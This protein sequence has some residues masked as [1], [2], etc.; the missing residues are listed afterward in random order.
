[1]CPMSY[2]AWAKLKTQKA[3]QMHF[4][5]TWFSVRFGYNWLY[6]A[7][8]VRW[9]N[10][11]DS[12]VLLDTEH[13]QEFNT[14]ALQVSEIGKEQQL[15]FMPVSFGVDRQI[16]VLSWIIIHRTYFSLLLYCQVFF[17]LPVVNKNKLSKTVNT[18]NQ[19][20]CQQQHK[21]VTALWDPSGRK[22]TGNP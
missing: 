9:G 2:G 12:L 5:H 21:Y 18:S 8:K 11:I 14:A 22:R 3:H 15:Y 16:L 1:M 4:S 20:A 19:I 6:D 13:G 17:S 10:M 7:I